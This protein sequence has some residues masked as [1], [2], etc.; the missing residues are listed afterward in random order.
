[1]PSGLEALFICGAKTSSIFSLMYWGEV[2][3]LSVSVSF[4]NLLFLFALKSWRVNGVFTFYFLRIKNSS[5]SFIV[6][7]FSTLTVGYVI[8]HLDPVKAGN[9]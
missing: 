1:M 8:F 3:S 5:L 4:N 2:Y 9:Q 6:S 7:I